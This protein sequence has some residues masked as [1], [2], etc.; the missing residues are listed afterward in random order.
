[1]TPTQTAK[2]DPEATLSRH[3]QQRYASL[4][5]VLSE[6]GSAVVAFS[7]GVDSSLVLRV[8]ADSLGRANVLAAIA[9]SPSYP[10][11]EKAAALQFV[12]QLAVRFALLDTKEVS[13]PRYAN[14]PVNRCF[15]CKDELYSRFTELAEAEGF[16]AVLDGANVGDRGDHRPGMAAGRRLGIRSPLLEAELD[17]DDVRRLAR[18]LGL[19]MWN[20]P[21]AACLASRIPYN[22]PITPEL[23]RQVD[24]AEQVLQ[25]LGF[26]VVRVRHHGELARIELAPAEIERF[27]QAEIREAAVAGLQALGYRFVTL[28]LAGY[29]TGSLNEGVVRIRRRIQL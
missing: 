21:A 3:L 12:R 22:T 28:D 18:H 15:F 14:N 11:R 5:Q 23:L 17:K 29:R 4:Q 16:A 7:G 19:P 27:G 6:L 20:K 24:R 9:I 26:S 25:D 13:D 8:A 10:E 1:M 2:H